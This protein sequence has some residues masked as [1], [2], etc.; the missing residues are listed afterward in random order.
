MWVRV[1]VVVVFLA[2]VL[3]TVLRSPEFRDWRAKRRSSRR[4]ND[5]N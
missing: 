3:L 2:L 4:R 1:A 5:E